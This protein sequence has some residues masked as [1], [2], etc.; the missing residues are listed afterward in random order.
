MMAKTDRSDFGSL[1]PGMRGGLFDC[2]NRS[3]R[4]CHGKGMHIARQIS[5]RLGRTAGARTHSAADYSITATLS[6]VPDPL[7]TAMWISPEF[8]V[9]LIKEFQ[10]LK[11]EEQAQLGWSA[12]REL[13]KIAA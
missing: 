6:V 4:E 1:F 5:R 9:Y 11:A 13:A 7:E 8:K 10:R 3:D 12:K 2:Q